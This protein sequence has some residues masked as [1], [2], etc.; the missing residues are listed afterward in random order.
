MSQD[1]IQTPHDRLVK[2]VFS[3]PHNAASQLQSLLPAAVIQALDLSTLT[4]QAGEFIDKQLRAKESDLLFAAQLKGQKNRQ[5][6]VY[7]LYEHLSSHPKDRFFPLRLLTYM[8]RIWEQF[9][10]QHPKAKHLPVIIPV[11]IYHGAGRWR[12]CRNFASLFDPKTLGKMSHYV[13]D[14]TYELE[15]LQAAQEHELRER[16]V[17]AHVK[18]TLWFLKSARNDKQLLQ[19]LQEWQQVLQTL[20]ESPTGMDAFMTLMRYYMSVAQHPKLEEVQTQVAQ[21][22]GPQTQEGVM[23]LAERLIREGKAEGKAEGMAEGVIRALHALFDARGW[24]LTKVQHRR[25]QA[26]HDLSTL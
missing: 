14:L 5:A 7:V 17:L 12:V 25:I 18:A 26:C 13:P 1:S 22:L 15:D 10:K 16:A 20:L 21:V 2:Q 9:V 24:K 4:L 11:V 19:H 23:T 6:F 3:D 8:G